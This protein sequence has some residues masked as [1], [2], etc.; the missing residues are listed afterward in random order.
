[1]RKRRTKRCYFSCIKKSV[2]F[3][4]FRF[5]FSKNRLIHFNISDLYKNWC[6]QPIHI[7]KVLCLR[8]YNVTITIV[9][10]MYIFCSFFS[11][12]EFATHLL[13][14]CVFMKY[15]SRCHMLSQVFKTIV[16]LKRI[17]SKNTGVCFISILTSGNFI[18]SLFLS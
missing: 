15:C 4:G 6:S 13:Y 5:F 1:M 16:Q 3:I 18:I 2:I 12:T 7:I 10:Q 9:T 14:F 11:I 8:M 17:S